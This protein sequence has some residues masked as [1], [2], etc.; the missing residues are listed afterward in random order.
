MGVWVSL[1][2]FKSLVTNIKVEIEHFREPFC[3][4]IFRIASI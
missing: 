4:L 2:I 3:S 1:S